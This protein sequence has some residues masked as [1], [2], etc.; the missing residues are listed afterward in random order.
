VRTARSIATFIHP[1]G[2]KCVAL[3]VRPKKNK[4][5]PFRAD[6][7]VIIKTNAVCRRLTTQSLRTTG[8]VRTLVWNVIGFCCIAV[9]SMAGSVTSHGMLVTWVRRVEASSWNQIMP[10][11]ERHK[12]IDEC[13]VNQSMTKAHHPGDSFDLEPCD[14]MLFSKVKN[15]LKR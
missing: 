4:A 2:Q 13:W 14:I 5:I 9:L 6:S 8:L 7:T 3:D 11:R 10:D 1:I 15:K 12:E